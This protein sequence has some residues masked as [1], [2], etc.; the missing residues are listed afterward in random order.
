MFRYLPIDQRVVSLIAALVVG[1]FV[2]QLLT[3]TIAFGMS[4]LEAEQT[5]VDP[6]SSDEKEG[7]TS[8]ETGDATAGTEIETEANTTEVEQKEALAGETPS[9]TEGTAPDML[10][11]EAPLTDGSSSE[12]AIYLDVSSEDGLEVTATN[13]ATTTTEVEVLADTGENVASGSNVSIDT[14]DAVAYADILTVVNTNIVDSDGLIDFIN[15]TLG[16]ADFDMRDEYMLIYS[17]F[18]T[19]LSTPACDLSVCNDSSTIVNTDNSANIQN[20]VTVTANTGGNV[21]TG[22]TAAI[23]T[24]DAYASANLINVANTN[25]IESNYLLL[26][27][28]NFADYAGDIILPNSD[29]FSQLLAGSGGVS[30]ASIAIDNSADITN[31][32]AVTADT[33]NNE[34]IGGVTN[35]TTGDVG[36]R[37]DVTNLINQN[38]IG[39][40]AFSMLIRVHGNWSGEVFGLPEGL[41]WRETDQGIEIFAL[42]PG[43][44]SVTHDLSVSTKNTAVINNNVQVFALTGDNKSGGDTAAVTTGNAYADSSILNIANTNVIGSNWSNLIFNIY[45]NWSGNLTFGQSN[46]WLGV[47]A[48]SSDSPIMPGSKVTYTFTVFNQGDTTASDVTLESLSQGDILTF[49]DGNRESIADTSKHSWSLGDIPA[50]TTREF[51]YVAEV[52]DHLDGDIVTAIPLTSRVTSFQPDADEDDNQDIVTVYVGEKRSNS[53]SRKATFPAHFDITKTASRDLAQPGDTVDY[54]VTFFNRGG[55]LFDAMLVDTL[56]D[57]NGEIVQQQSWPLGEIKNWETISVKYSIGFDSTMSTGVYRNYAQLVGFHES[58]KER[59][60]TP[61][62]SSVAMHELY[63]GTKPEGLVLGAQDSVCSPYLTTYLRFDINNDPDEVRKLQHFLNQELGRSLD[64]SGFFDLATEQAVRDFQLIHREEVLIPWGLERDSGFVYYTTQKKIN[65]IMCGGRSF[66]L[67]PDQNAEMTNYREQ[68]IGA[69]EY[70]FADHDSLP[71][72]PIPTPVVPSVTS[73]QVV[74]EKVIEEVSGLDITS[75]DPIS[76]QIEEVRQNKWSRVG[77][78]CRDMFGRMTSLWR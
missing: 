64:I 51:S 61:Y 73:Q 15:T 23:T 76:N 57:E 77:D 13:T 69:S 19:S 53:S 63:L 37:S 4:E 21:A 50:G 18:D 65:E 6:S 72:V 2:L 75:F 29:F 74:R 5:A 16:Y 66:P 70:N 58:K 34:A 52:T 22:D 41:S 38:I 3:P 20:D 71:V 55:Q 12:N 78:W 49:A 68:I 45:G 30:N 8:V 24:G 33:G 9:D 54:E 35:I 7:S 44:G 40:S 67:R 39:G 10:V 47:A 36:A 28:N 11:E 32:T 43:N 46:L 59:Y 48:N 17:D 42:D 26:V 27:F 1:S 25:I 56:E 62:E 60:Q 14:G 31:A